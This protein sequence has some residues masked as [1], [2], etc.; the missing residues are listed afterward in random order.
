[1]FAHIIGGIDA[2]NIS[3]KLDT[4]LIKRSMQLIKSSL[5]HKQ[6]V[7]LINW[8]TCVEFINGFLTA[9]MYIILFLPINCY[10]VK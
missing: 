9:N 8:S 5:K 2:T 1:M 7:V 6:N 4:N 10:V 3:D